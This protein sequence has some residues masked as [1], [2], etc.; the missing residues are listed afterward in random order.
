MLPLVQANPPLKVVE[1]PA[2]KTVLDTAR[3]LRVWAGRLPDHYALSVTPDLER[4]RLDVG[5]IPLEHPPHLLVP[6]VRKAAGPLWAHIVR[7]PLV[8][9]P[10]LV[11][12]LLG[13]QEFWLEATVEEYETV[14]GKPA[15]DEETLVQWARDRGGVDPDGVHAAFD[16]T[17]PEVEVPLKDL[18]DLPGHAGRVARLLE[19]VKRAPDPVIEWPPAYESAAQLPGFLLLTPAEDPPIPPKRALEALLD[20]MELLSQQVEVTFEA[21]SIPARRESAFAL[22]RRWHLLDRL[23]EA[24]AKWEEDLARKNREANNEKPRAA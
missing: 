12:Y 10:D 4:A 16:W 21:A 1:N 8:P 2:Y 11:E 9:L 15:P 13:E 22:A 24:I 19:L 14:V 7:T 23:F 3:P 18:L 20:A 5:Q 6:R 17:V